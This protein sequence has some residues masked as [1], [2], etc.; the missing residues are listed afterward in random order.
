MITRATRLPHSSLSR[1]YKHGHFKSPLLAACLC[2]ESYPRVHLQLF[3]TRGSLSLFLVHI[4]LLTARATN[5]VDTSS[6][7]SLFLVHNWLLPT[8]TS[9]RVDTSGSLSLLLV[10][11]WT[12]PIRT[13]VFATSGSLSLLLVYVWTLPIRIS[14]RVDT[15]GSLSLL[16]VHIWL[17]PTRTSNRV[18]TSGSLSLLLV[19]VWTLPIR[20]SNRVDTS[21]SLSL[22]LGFACLAYSYTLKVEVVDPCGTSMNF[23]W[24]TQS[25]LQ[26]VTSFYSHVCEN[27]VQC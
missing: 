11:V 16:L 10:Y 7:L 9:N 17:L 27:I 5:R 25:R 6:S 12:L 18:D 21:G 26:E 3:A 23:F 22:L 20:T 2:L 14:N 8:R 15:S 19:Y 13:S 4:W 1:V 24:I